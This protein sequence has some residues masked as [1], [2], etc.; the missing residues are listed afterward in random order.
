MS[1]DE[2]EA[3]YG[4]HIEELKRKE[5][6][7]AKSSLSNLKKN[8]DYEIVK[9]E[10][11]DDAK[12]FSPYVSWCVTKR[13][14]YFDNYTNGGEKTFYFAVRKDFKTVPKDD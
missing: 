8:E 13:N 2:L 5:R 1:F 4:K 12:K 10:S 9:I 11:F 6:E 7:E 3:K 14:G